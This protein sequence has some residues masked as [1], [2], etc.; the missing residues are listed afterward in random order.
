QY[1]YPLDER[2]FLVTLALPTP[3]GKLGRFN[4]YLIDIH[5]RREL[6]VEGAESGDGIGCKQ[7]IPLAARERPH[8]RPSLA[9]Y[10][11]ATGTVY[12]Q[13]IHEGPGLRGIPRGTVRRLRVV[14]VRYQAASFGR[15]AQS[16]KGG[17]SNVLTPIAIGHGSWDVK[18]VLGSV[19]IHTDG[20]A[21]FEVPA[22]TPIYFQA[23]DANGYVVQTMRSWTT[24]MPGEN[25]SCVGCHEPGSAAPPAGRRMVMALKDGPRRLT[26]FYGPPRGFSFATE[27]QP[28]LDRHCVRCHTGRKDKPFSLSGEAVEVDKTKR[29]FS[30]AYLALTHTRGSGGDWDHPVVNWIDS[31]SEPSMLPPYHRGAATSKLMRMLEKAHNDVK[32]SRE[33]MDKIACWIDLL[34]PY[35]GDFRESHAWSGEELDRYN[36]FLSKRKAMEDLEQAGIG[37]WI[38]RP[39]R[40]AP[41]PRGD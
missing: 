29:R 23:L 9:D 19:E 12:L 4:I 25:Q 3:E 18:D 31:M 38:N 1:P 7:I 14:A 15:L 8:V 13:D 26:P 2:R 22:R 16:G 40:R 37:A 20:S 5:G 11:K 6:L 39:Q 24:L 30:K 27:V 34:V 35:C 17:S 41:A 21:F 36:R 10:R 33:E 28:I 32:L